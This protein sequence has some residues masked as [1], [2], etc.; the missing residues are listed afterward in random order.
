MAQ[1][2]TEYIGE[3]GPG[4]LTQTGKT[5][6]SHYEFIGDLLGTPGGNGN[7]VHRTGNNNVS[8]LDLGYHSNLVDTSEN[9][10]GSY[11]LAVQ[12]IF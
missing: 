1:T 5:N 3:A 6:T 12:P 11:R 10:F 7:Y 2:G 4:T 9:A 8:E